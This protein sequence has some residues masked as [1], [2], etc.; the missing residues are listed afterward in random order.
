MARVLGGG[1]SINGTIAMVP[2]AE[3]FDGWA[4]LGNPDW[5]WAHVAPWFARLLG[6]DDGPPI[7][8]VEPT[9]RESFTAIQRAFHDACRELG[10]AEADLVEPRSLGVGGVPC[11]VRAGVRMS[12]DELYLNTALSR[13]N[14]VLRSGAV[15]ERILLE[16]G[17]AAAIG[18][19]SS[20][21]AGGG[22]RS[23]EAACTSGRRQ[24]R[25]SPGAV[26]VGGTPCGRLLAG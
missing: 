16:T 22:G 4:A 9:R 15:V 17:A 7:V 24:S 12:A 2:P 18:Y 21:C 8:P 6:A 20:R 10:H 5:S 1:S 11:N 19:R 14:L 3:D 13:D 26:P 25:R 23:G